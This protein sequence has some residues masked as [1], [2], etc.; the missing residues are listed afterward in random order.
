MRIHTE[1]APGT[2]RTPEATVADTLPT[3]RTV[4]SEWA[5][6]TTP[7]P[8]R[9]RA[10]PRRTDR[11]VRARSARPTTREQEPTDKRG[12]GPTCTATG[13]RVLYNAATTGRRQRTHR[14]TGAAHP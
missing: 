11:T 12:R 4:A 3:D 5:R 2:T 9:I 1:W 7:A 8:G 10:V 6:R 13:A 14:T